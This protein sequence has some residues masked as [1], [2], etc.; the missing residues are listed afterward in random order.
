MLLHQLHSSASDANAAANCVTSAGF[1]VLSNSACSTLTSPSQAHSQATVS[2]QTTKQL[3]GQCTSCLRLISLTKAD[4]PHSHG[5]G[6]ARSGQ[7]PAVGSKSDKKP[8]MSQAPAP[9]IPTN[10][11]NSDDISAEV[12]RSFNV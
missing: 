8:I 9:T 11:S 5:P 2:K 1:T 10:V 12:M 4:S 3:W 7:S 6:Y